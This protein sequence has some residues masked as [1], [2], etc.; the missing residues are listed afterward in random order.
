MPTRRLRSVGRVRLTVPRFRWR[1]FGGVLGPAKTDAGQSLA[2][3]AFSA[4][5][6]VV[7]GLTLASQEDQFVA[8]PGLL[9]FI[10]PAIGLR[11]NVF[12]P[13]GSRLSTNIQMGTFSWTWKVDSVLGQ[14]L[15]AV[16]INSL[17]ASLGISVLAE[18]LALFL[19]DE[20]VP[21]IGFSDFVVAGVL[22]GIVAS[23]V[24]LGFTLALTFAAVRLDL[25]L[26]NVVAPMVTAAGDL[27]TLPAL[28]L[29]LV[30]VRRGNTTLITATVLTIVTL[31]LTLWLVRSGLQI[32]RRIVAESLPVLLAA[33]S[34]SLIAGIAIESAEERLSWV[35]LVLLPGYLGT[36]GAL[37]GILANRLSTK[38]HLGIVQFNLWPGAEARSDMAFTAALAAPIFALLALVA[39][40]VA[41][42]AAQGTPGLLLL[43]AVAMTGGLA[44][45]LF[46]LA[47][48]YYGTL[49]SVRFG[50]DPDNIGIPLVTAA[51]DVVG[52]LSL[53]AA[54]VV[55]RVA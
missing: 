43:L 4:F 6:S 50:L 33:G 36:A 28:V 3:L 41:Q 20:G 49:A 21:P 1:P 29:S 19:G 31:A 52:A 23:I 30:L 2:A 46:V 8:L 34:L 12:G 18:L 45:T 55:W 15:V 14:N 39:E 38:V 42:A 13:L 7:A 47:I 27:I 5:T 54:V 11:G 53:V 16:L 25:D 48:A 32:A 35:M 40:V 17:L 37:G 44:S 51:L 24:V 9:L 26:D 22:G 10:P